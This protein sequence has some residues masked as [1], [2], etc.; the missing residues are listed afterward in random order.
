MFLQPECSVLLD[1]L[2]QSACHPEIAGVLAKSLL[3]ILQLSSEKTFS[4]LKTLDA[5]PRV[6]KVACVLAQEAK[7]PG[8]SIPS[9]ESNIDVVPEGFD[10][11]Q[12]PET[13]QNWCKSIDTLVE[14]F[15]EYL[16]VT[17]DA[18]SSVLHSYTCVDCLF[19]LFW[20]NGLRN[21]MLI[22]ILDLMKVFAYI[23]RCYADALCI[24]MVIV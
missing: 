20:D 23:L 13:A 8:N 19:Q 10:G 4:S 11:P 24:I 21:Q 2:E 9:A 15:V 7:R 5:I 3:R 12:S 17:D 6:L 18:K 16:S 14:L 1:A 22:H